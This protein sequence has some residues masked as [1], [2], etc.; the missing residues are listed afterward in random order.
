VEKDLKEDNAWQIYF[1]SIK[2]VCPWSLRAF[3]DNNIL[4]LDYSSKTYNTWGSI[5]HASK[6]EAFV[7]KCVDKSVDWLI[8]KCEE[9]NKKSTRSEWLWSHPSEGGNSTPVP[10]LIQQDREQLESLRD[11]IGYEHGNDN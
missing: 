6:H 2:G 3:M 7:Y 5:F 9:L 8:D 4:F 1:A 11:K 10:V